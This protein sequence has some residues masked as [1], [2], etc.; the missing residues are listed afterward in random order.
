MT[1][2]SAAVIREETA[3]GLVRYFVRSTRY[4]ARPFSD[5]CPMEDRWE[6][7]RA[8]PVEALRGEDDMLH[9]IVRLSDAPRATP[10]EAARDMWREIHRDLDRHGGAR[11]QYGDVPAFTVEGIPVA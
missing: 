3:T 7:V 11:L 4:R 10:E 6:A 1:K 9:R 5:T 2:L 8:E